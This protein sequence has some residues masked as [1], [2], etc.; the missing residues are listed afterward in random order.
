MRQLSVV[1]LSGFLACGSVHAQGLRAVRPLPGY[2][3]MQLAISPEQLADPKGG[4][5]ILDAPSRSAAVANYASAVVIVKDP[6][7]GSGGFL[8]VLRLTGEEGWIE[9][10]YLRPWSNPYVPTARC[11]PS[12][13]SNGRPGFGS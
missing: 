11:V 3:C 5:P 2:I 1:F 9:A 7:R 6:P 12:L 8:Q 4:I 10:R 13:M